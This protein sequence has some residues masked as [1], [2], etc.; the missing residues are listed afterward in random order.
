MHISRSFQIKECGSL[1]PLNSFFKGLF[2]ASDV[3]SPSLICPAHSMCAARMQVSVEG[4]ACNSE[5]GLR[6]SEVLLSEVSRA[7]LSGHLMPCPM[8]SFQNCLIRVT[9]RGR[10][11]LVTDFG[12]AREVVELPVKD[13][14]RKLSLVGSA[15]WMA[16][17][18]LRGEPYD[19][20]V[21]HRF[22]LLVHPQSS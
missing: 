14:E 18:M 20:K 13:V 21:W 22:H 15:F 5:V 9:P 10:E 2:L 7:F 3:I 17:E 6:A 4:R 16:P 19:R 1:C 8:G 12:L 11:A